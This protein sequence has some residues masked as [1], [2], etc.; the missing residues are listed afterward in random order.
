MKYFWW[1]SRSLDLQVH[2]D[3]YIWQHIFSITNKHCIGK[4]VVFGLVPECHQN[5]DRPKETKSAEHWLRIPW[6][7]FGFSWGGSLSTFCWWYFSLAGL[8]L[9][10]KTNYLGAI[11]DT[12]AVFWPKYMYFFSG[13][14]ML[15]LQTNVVLSGLN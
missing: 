15:I 3:N 12:E 1:F 2:K 9:V 6:R 4:A 7:I 8:T 13:K 5:S 11:Q 14:L 10:S